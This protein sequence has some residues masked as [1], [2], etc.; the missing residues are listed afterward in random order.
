MRRITWLGHATVLVESG[1]ARLLT[2]PVLRGRILHLRRHAPPAPDPGRLDGVLVSHVHYDHLDKPSLRRVA[3]PDVAAVIPAGAAKYVQGA[4]FGRVHEVRA[5][6]TVEVG[7]ARVQ[8]VPAWH[9]GR[10]H[11][12]KEALETLGFLVDGIWFAGDTDIDAGMEA[13]R[14]RVDVAL[15]PIW[16]WGPTLGPGH[17]DPKRAAEAVALIEPRLVVPIHWGTYLPI[18]LGKRHKGLLSSP[19]AELVVSAKEL[20]PAA[21]V[22]RVPPNGSLDL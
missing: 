11:P 3:A 9:D 1:G 16:G 8:A 17:L 6:E 18:G 7:G 14:G 19:A 2:D 4:G 10:R 22:E 21:R 20:A 5:G 13:L 12:G 15:L